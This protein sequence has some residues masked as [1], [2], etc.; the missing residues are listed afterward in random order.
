MMLV[1]LPSYAA[2]SELECAPPLGP[3]AD[4]RAAFHQVLPGITFNEFGLGQVNRPDHTILLDLGD[5][6]SVWTATIDVTG[7]GAASA[8]AR[9]MEQTGWRTYAP[10]LGRFIAVKD[11]V[12]RDP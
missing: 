7:D 5:S 1:N 11:L 2:A 10:R 3:Q 9:L 6:A 4:V 12:S 8:L